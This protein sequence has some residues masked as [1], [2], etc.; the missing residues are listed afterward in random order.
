MRAS[1]ILGVTLLLLSGA[2]LAAGPEDSAVVTTIGETKIE[3]TVP[4]SRL[5]LTLPKG[6]FGPVDAALTGSQKNPRYFHLTDLDKGLVISGWI[7][8]AST[9]VG[10]KKFW[11]G[12]FDALKKSGMAPTGEPVPMNTGDWVA[13]AYEFPL[14][15]GNGTNSHLRAELVKHGTWVDLHISITG[16]MTVQEARAAT[17]AL[18]RSI[19]VTKKPK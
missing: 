17:F 4:A 11:E 13:K 8:P 18:L 14:P 15:A 2:V 10:F 5:L 9:F 6:G 16:R 3:I 7:E 1:N 19:E 12:E